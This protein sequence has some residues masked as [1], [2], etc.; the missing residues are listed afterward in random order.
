MKVC[1]VGMENLSALVRDFNPHGIGGEQVQ[2]TLLARAL[3]GKGY[4]VSMVVG[5]YGQPDGASWSGVTAFKAYKAEAGIPIVR[6]FHPRWTGVWKALR[7]ADADVYYTSCAGM[8]VGLVAIFCRMYGRGLVFRLASDADAD[9]DRL[10]IQYRRDK[11]LYA[12]G[13]RRA[14]AVLSQHGTQQAALCHNYGVHSAVADMFVESPERD[15]ELARRD[16]P[17]LWVSNLRGIKR[18]DRVVDLARRLCDTQI[19]MVGGAAPGA[20]ALYE[21]TRLQASDVPNLEFHGGVSYHEVGGFFDRARVF[22]NTSDVEGFPNSYL[23]AWRRGIPVVSFFDPDDIIQR[24]GLGYAVSSMEQ[25]ASA[26][27]RMLS[28]DVEWAALSARCRSYMEE[29]HGDDVV[30]K[31]YIEAIEQAAAARRGR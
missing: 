27:E 16:M 2:Q 15:V 19:H 10:L 28:D 26:V 23:Q 8:M 6:F 9:P 12:F 29:H 21:Q 22:I 4:R 31:P 20:Q 14:H 1:L 7:R 3:L 11:A 25:M 30:L 18:P 17:V 24:Q 5:D 13:L